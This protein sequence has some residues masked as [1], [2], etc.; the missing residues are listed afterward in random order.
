MKNTY[1]AKTRSET[2]FERL[3]AELEE[4]WQ[5]ASEW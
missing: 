1:L 5:T 2:V 4:L 3:Q